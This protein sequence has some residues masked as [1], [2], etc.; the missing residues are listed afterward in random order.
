MTTLIVFREGCNGHYLQAIVENYPSDQA[1]FRMADD[2]HSQKLTCLTHEVNFQS[3][4]EK[5]KNALRILPDKKIY[6]AIYNNF[7]KKMLLEDFSNFNISDWNKDIIFW[8]DRCYH[9]IVEYFAL[10]CADVSNNVYTD[11]VNF[12]LLLSQD[13]V[14]S[15]LKTYFDT[16]MN[17]NQIAMIKKYSDLQLS[18]DLCNDDARDMKTIMEPL[19]DSMFESNPWFFSYC[20]FKYEHNNKLSESM[21]AWSVNS[22]TRRQTKHDLMELSKQYH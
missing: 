10:H 17:N 3:H 22:F 18:I 11:V 2:N 9:N 13:Y 5:F 16:S 15:I 8:Y 20:I 6:N 12:D 14:D 1:R 4:V 7:M 21:R 19:S